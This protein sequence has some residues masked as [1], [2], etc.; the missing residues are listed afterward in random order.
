MF[1]ALSIVLAGLFLTGALVV[2]FRFDA[3]VWRVLE[4]LQLKL[5]D[6]VREARLQPET[7]DAQLN[8]VRVGGVAASMV[9]GTLILLDGTNFHDVGSA[10]ASLLLYAFVSTLGGI[11][12]VTTVRLW[13]GALRRVR[14][15]T[16]LHACGLRGAW[17]TE[18]DQS[19]GSFTESV[20]DWLGDS[21]HVGV[22]DITGYD[23]L[24]KGGWLHEAILNAPDV[25]VSVLL[26]KPGVSDKDPER[27]QATVFQTVLADLGIS[28]SAYERRLRATV[29][30]IRLMNETRAPEGQIQLNYYSEK[31]TFQ[32][33]FF[34]RQ[35][36]V[37]P[38]G[39]FDNPKSFLHLEAAEDGKP[40]SCFE[41]FWRQFARL[42]G[43]CSSKSIRRA[44]PRQATATRDRA[45]PAVP[46]A[47][48]AVTASAAPA[49]V[50]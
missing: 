37:A 48:K 15:A 24:V 41:I 28:A 10:P 31:P 17:V 35:A 20:C 43:T 50:A 47:V 19:T 27:Q 39:T 4:F 21:S 30:T 45:R 29:E 2:P 3:V 33:V 49:G 22:L 42:W 36:L 25:P 14:A 18:P 34:D 8:W 26:L 38:C 44:R 13:A 40:P 16:T 46:R 32:G 12:F 9:F 23:A 5:I 6:R 7:D 1:I 11:A